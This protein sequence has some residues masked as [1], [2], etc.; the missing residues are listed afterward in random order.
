MRTLADLIAFNRAH[1]AQEMRFFG[2]EVFEAAEATNGL[3]ASYRAARALCLD[4]TAPQLTAA[5]S[6]SSASARRPRGTGRGRPEQR[7]A[8][9]RAGQLEPAGA[10]VGDRR[11]LRDLD[12]LLGDRARCLRSSRCS[13]GSASVIA[14]PSRP[15]RPTRPMRC[16]YASGAD[17]TS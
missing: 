5:R 7:L 12:P 1:C 8:Q 3:D 10:Q 6:N 2:Q 13:R 16:T 4:L 15:A 14:T 11:H 17:G 9:R